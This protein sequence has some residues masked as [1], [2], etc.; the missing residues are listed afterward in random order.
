MVIKITNI[1]I[2]LKL[3]REEKGLSQIQLGLKFNIS[4][5]SISSY[6]LGKSNPSFEILCKYADFFRV[7]LD[8]IFGRT[9]IKVSIQENNLNPFEAYFI[10]CYRSLSESGK[11]MMSKT[12]AA[13]KDADEEN[14]E[15][16]S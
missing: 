14:Q 9:D 7:S 6:E 15:M 5:E 12:V 1:G 10:D 16:F 8:Y 2:A 3:L 11:N 13:I 4:Q